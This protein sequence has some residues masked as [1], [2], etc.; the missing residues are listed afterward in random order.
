MQ[1]WLHSFIIIYLK[2]ETPLTYSHPGKHIWKVLLQPLPTFSWLRH[3]LTVLQTQ[4]CSYLRCSRK[5]TPNW[6]FIEKWVTQL[7]T[8]TDSQTHLCRQRA[9]CRE[10]KK[11]NQKFMSHFEKGPPQN[12]W[13][14]SE[15]FYILHLHNKELS[16]GTL[17]QGQ[18]S[19]ALICFPRT[20]IPS[21]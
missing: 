7:N 1:K 14:W 10:R 11:T 9:H 17:N 21:Q 4:H 15:W 8:E 16:L 3:V 19:L 6:I 12:N 5:N 20:Q 18:L 2:S 13:R